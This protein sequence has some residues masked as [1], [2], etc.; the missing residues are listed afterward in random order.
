V[1]FTS[2]DLDPAN[3]PVGVLVA[4]PDGS[5]LAAPGNTPLSDCFGVHASSGIPY[6]D[7]YPDPGESA[8]LGYDGAKGVFFVRT[9]ETPDSHL[10]RLSSGLR[11]GSRSAPVLSAWRRVNMRAAAAG[12]R[13]RDRARGVTGS[14]APAR[15]V[16]PAAGSPGQ[17]DRAQLRTPVTLSFAGALTAGAGRATARASVVTLAGD[18]S[19]QGRA[20]ARQPRTLAVAAHGHV[21]RAAAR[22]PVTLTVADRGHTA[23]AQARQPRTLTVTS[24]A[25]AARAQAS[26]PQTLPT[27]THLADAQRARARDRRKEL[28]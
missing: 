19:F 16:A 12:F 14:P 1:S 26:Q 23:R 24:H 6:F 21:A 5:P 4:R 15:M 9:G 28:S 17:T 11:A 13:A 25:S 18:G 20:D 22:Q 7:P 10:M 3:S 2:L 8:S 27:D